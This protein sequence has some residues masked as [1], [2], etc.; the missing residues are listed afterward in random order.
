[1]FKRN[2]WVVGHKNP[3]TDSI[4]AAIAYA[5][6]KNIL[7]MKEGDTKVQYVP[8]RA[9]EVNAETSYVL[10][11]FGVE[12]P[13][14]I[15]DVGTQLKDIMYRRT[16]GV[17]SQ[18]SLKKAW[19][20]MRSLDVVT[21]A[22]VNAANKLEGIVVTG[23]IAESYM[24][25]Y[26]NRVLSNAKTQYKN[27]VDTLD[28]KRI[29]G[30]DQAYFV[31]GKVVLATGSPD[32][33]R[34]MLEP[35]DLVI[36]GDYEEVQLI[37]IEEGCSC[38]VVSDNLNISDKV[39]KK[40]NEHGVILICSPYDAFTVSRLINQS[41][42]LKSIMTTPEEIVSFELDD[43]VD[44]VRDIT[45]KIRHRDF[46]ILDEKQNYVGMFSRRYLLNAQKKQLILVDHNEKSQAVN[47]VADAEILEI[48]DH[49]R[50]GSLETIA[51]VMFR[52][53]P[54]G[55][56]STIIYQMYKEK[57]VEVTKEIAGILCSAIVSD[58]LMFRSPTCTEVDEAAAEELAKI[59][60]IEIEEL[61]HG[62]FEAGSDFDNKTEEEILNQD[63][64]IFYM[65]DLSFGVSQV[66]AMGQP[67]L[68]RVRER[69]EKKLAA[70]CGEKGVQMMYV[71]LTDIMTEKTTLIYYGNGAESIAKEAFNTKVINGALELE[72]IVSR[73]K[74]LIPALMNALY[75]RMF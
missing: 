35:G 14:Y 27:I 41:M 8:S 25:A 58:T 22:V 3:D 46:P 13:E 64:K 48:V 43:F 29:T 24:D 4:C 36:V 56:T 30:D 40:A 38:M 66:S 59:A 15:S 45:A 26:D 53:Q 31:R 17:S 62:M 39:I 33:T 32:V 69:V 18:L 60:E 11:R 28:G 70:M 49:H 20:L 65:S 67:A 50:L 23:D 55:S 44:E 54:L 57:N 12:E 37:S 47:N 5:N 51:P 52:N 6:L 1:M 74:Q 9:G 63:F 71:M 61:A 10:S 19:E 42:P 16:A 21:L 68:D 73:K 7:A 75:E 72:G 2:V 34:S